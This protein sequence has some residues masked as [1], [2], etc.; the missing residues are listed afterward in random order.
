MVDKEPE[1]LVEAVVESE[2]V[3]DVEPEIIP[4]PTPEPEVKVVSVP[5][6]APAPLVSSS[7]SGV[8]VVDIFGRVAHIQIPKN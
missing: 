4:L 3:L 1:N 8:T 7:D 2:A 5:T 6:P